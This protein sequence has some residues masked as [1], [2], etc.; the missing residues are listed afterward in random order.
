MAENIAS[1]EFQKIKQQVIN[2]IQNIDDS[3]AIQLSELYTGLLYP[4]DN[5][6]ILQDL[7]KET[8]NVLERQA[9]DFASNI[10]FNVLE[11]GASLYA[12]AS[13]NKLSS[14]ESFANSTRRGIL[15]NITRALNNLSLTKLERQN[16]EK[17]QMDIINSVEV[18]GL[19]GDV[20]AKGKGQRFTL[21]ERLQ[22]AFGKTVME[23]FSSYYTGWLFENYLPAIR[24]AYQNLTKE[25]RQNIDNYLDKIGFHSIS[26]A[27][28]VGSEKVE[29]TTGNFQ[30]ENIQVNVTKG[31]SKTDLRVAI[32]SEFFN[33]SLKNIGTLISNEGLTSGAITIE[34]GSTLA[35]LLYEGMSQDETYVNIFKYYVD[36]KEQNELSIPVGDIKR[37]I[38]AKAIM[39]SGV[40]N[41]VDMTAQYFIV[42]DRIGRKIMVRSMRS[43]VEKLLNGKDN[44]FLDNIEIEGEEKGV[45]KTL[46]PSHYNF[47]FV[48]AWKN[49]ISNEV[50]TKISIDASLLE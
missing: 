10:D 17:L 34:H 43:I 27:E 37:L 1:K 2:K 31:T 29:K 30:G 16:L 48:D 6:I 7:L 5:S 21:A 22:K 35:K 50:K 20:K 9:D 47:N 49:F 18:G 42:N 4:G 12:T 3:I 33:L 8:Q 38:A 19:I 40:K 41:G 39:G 46:N 13:N 28:V 24:E 11:G 15:N 25:Q 45:D 14:V 44:A 26:E 36:Q 23:K 32:N